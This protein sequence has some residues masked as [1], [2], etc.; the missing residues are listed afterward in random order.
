MRCTG[1]AE[2]ELP[3]LW[4]DEKCHDGLPCGSFKSGEGRFDKNAIGRK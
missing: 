1:N 3:I 4:L 2:D